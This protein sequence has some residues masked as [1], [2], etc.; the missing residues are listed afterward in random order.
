MNSNN[1]KKI[2]YLSV[3]FLLLNCS[4]KK[5]D[6]LCDS[7]DVKTTITQSIGHLD[8]FEQRFLFNAISYKNDTT[9]LGRKYKAYLKSYGNVIKYEYL[10]EKT[11]STNEIADK[12]KLKLVNEVFNTYYKVQMQI[13]KAEGVENNSLSFYKK[14]VES[15]L[16]ASEAKKISTND[17]DLIAAFTKLQIRF[18]HYETMNSI[19]M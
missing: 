2:L 13:I 19:F 12:E 14:Q 15:C 9:V 7:I 8:F 1:I 5:E 18:I 4:Q 16:L 17:W 6:S 10:I 3:V 11:I